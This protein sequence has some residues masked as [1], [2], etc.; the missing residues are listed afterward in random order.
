MLQVLQTVD[1][2]VLTAGDLRLE[3]RLEADRWQHCVLIWQ[4]GLYTP[5][6]ESLEGDPSD[7]FPPSPA[8]QELM[9]EK[10]SDGCQEV[11]LFGRAGKNLYAA[12][13]RVDMEAG[14][15]AFDVSVR[16]RGDQSPQSM[17]SSYRLGE[18]FDAAS[19]GLNEAVGFTGTDPLEFV[20]QSTSVTNSPS[21]GISVT[22]G[23]ELQIGCFDLLNTDLSGNAAALRWIYRISPSPHS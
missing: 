8:F 13:I 9:L 12:A 3:C 23:K 14:E 20:L 21:C 11:Q 22:P 1:R 5:L 17:A 4:D 7:S 16:M 2:C 19:T 6:L 15:I 10:K 18:D